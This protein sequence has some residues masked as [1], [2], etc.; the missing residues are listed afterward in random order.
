MKKIIIVL[1]LSFSVLSFSMPNK[2]EKIDN[3]KLYNAKVKNAFLSDNCYNVYITFEK[4]SNDDATICLNF[5]RL[6]KTLQSAQR[7]VKSYDYLYGIMVDEDGEQIFN[8][9][10]S[11]NAKLQDKNDYVSLAREVYRQ[12]IITSPFMPTDNLKKF[13]EEGNFPSLD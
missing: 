6:C 11:K 13:I 10:L 2:I 8:L 12:S 1:L 3:F 7:V 9:T 5:L 4:S